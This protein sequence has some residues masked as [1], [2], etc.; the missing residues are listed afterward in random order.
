MALTLNVEFSPGE[1]ITDAFQEAVSLS[2]KLM[3]C[4]DFKF[5]NVVCMVK[6]FGSVRKGVE[7]YHEA[8][9]S[10]SQ[11]KFAKSF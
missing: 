2:D 3:V 5:N 7:S 9:K 6:P 1:D 10:D 8:I 4:I 11:Y